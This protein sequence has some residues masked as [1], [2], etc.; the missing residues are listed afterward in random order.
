MLQGGFMMFDD[1]MGK[2]TPGVK[3]ALDEFL[4]DKPE[5]VI[6]TTVGQCVLIKQ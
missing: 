4:A 3:I 6:I 5:K 2:N 1:Y